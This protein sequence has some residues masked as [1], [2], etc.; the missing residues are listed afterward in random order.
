MS[1]AWRVQSLEGFLAHF[2]GRTSLAQL[3][4]KGER[5]LNTDDRTLVEF[6]FARGLGEPSRFDMDE[7][8]RIA[9]ARNE[10]RPARLTGSVVWDNVTAN[11]AS[12]S[13]VIAF[14]PRPTDTDI[15]RHRA[16]VTYDMGNLTATL[17]E[18][19][20]HSWPPANSD[21]L[22]MI[23]DS[24]AD[25]GSEV[26]A[27]YAEQLRAWEPVDA[28]LVL[29]RLRWRQ[30]RLDEAVT[31][32][33]RAFIAARRDP[34][35]TSDAMGRALDL[36]VQL[37]ATHKYTPMLIDALSQP[38]A[39]GQWEDAR[40]WYL[41]N[42][43]HTADGC[44]PRTIHALRTLEPWPPWQK[45]LLQLRRDCYASAM[46]STLFRRAER[47]LAAFQASEPQPLH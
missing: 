17:A 3:M 25:G 10:D 37:A 15:A 6:G 27:T 26:A 30:S 21:E 12:T 32:L 44:G 1:H 11:R 24:L 43:T 8:A 31:V 45:E 9:A 38:F 47:D 40:R 33:H 16:A 46:M 22:M 19:R 5:D 4:A 20:A 28:D 13:Y 2:I 29:A 41:A 42:I 7:L 14:A 36:A 23:A 34:W 18:W 39:A 35:M